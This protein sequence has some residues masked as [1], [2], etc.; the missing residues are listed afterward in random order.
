LAGHFRRQPS[1]SCFIRFPGRPVA[2]GWGSKN[3]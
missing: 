2:D 3:L 1:S